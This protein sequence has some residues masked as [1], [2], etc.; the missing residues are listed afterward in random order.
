MREAEM[1]MDK[2]G[3]GQLA[4]VFASVKDYNLFLILFRKL[5]W[6]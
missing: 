4:R 5:F 1:L 6:K 3:G 2:G